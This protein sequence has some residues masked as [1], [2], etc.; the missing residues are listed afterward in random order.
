MPHPLPQTDAPRAPDIRLGQ[1]APGAGVAGFVGLLACLFLM[2][3]GN[4]NMR[5]QMFGS[6]MFGWV[7]WLSISLGMLGLTLLHHTVRGSW[8]LSI[9][10]IIEAGGSAANFLLLAALLIP[11]ILNLP[12]L[13]EWAIPEVVREDGIIAWKTPY[14]NANS[15]ILQWS[16]FFAIWAALAYVMRQSTLSQDA[17]RNFEHERKRQYWGGAALVVF[18]LTITFAFILFVMSM[19]PHWASTMY[20]V[21]QMI[22]AAI[23]GLSFAVLV[24]CTQ[25][26]R[27]PFRQVVAPGLTKDLGNMMFAFTM[28]WGYTSVSQFLIIWNGNI[29]EFTQYF[30]R[31][32]SEYESALGGGNWGALGML[33]LLGQFFIPFFWLLSPRTKRTPENLMKVAGWMFFIHILDIYMLVV[34]AI[35]G[36]THHGMNVASR[37][38]QGPL[39]F[40]PMGTDILA[41]FTVG[42]LWLAFF[43]AQ[44]RQA[45]LIPTYDHRLQEAKAH[46]H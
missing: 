16:L 32:S 43:A 10:R 29:P 19:E 36:H 21:W 44:T 17:D 34:P 39:A 11:V 37:A 42:A 14:L 25:A 38:S 2:F 3:T 8:T 30:A 22:G 41:W 15:Y 26:H 31:R 40:G 1:L 4:D 28:L 24:L 6:W 46:A 7:F 5:A 33:L 45:A 12:M 20:G 23:G 9:L 35:P 27:E 18:V 13:Y